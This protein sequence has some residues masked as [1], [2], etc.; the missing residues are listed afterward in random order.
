MESFWERSNR[1]EHRHHL[2]GGLYPAMKHRSFY[3]DK[4]RSGP[5][6]LGFAQQAEQEPC[7]IVPVTQPTREEIRYSGVICTSLYKK[8]KRHRFLEE[9][10]DLTI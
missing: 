9:G 4:C 10:L 6:F 2:V 5:D 1:L 7:N 8:S 3:L